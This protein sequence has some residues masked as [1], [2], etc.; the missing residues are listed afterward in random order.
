MAD[1]L[2]QKL[3]EI[4]DSLHSTSPHRYEYAAELASDL[5]TLCTEQ[6]TET[7]LGRCNGCPSCLWAW[8]VCVCVCG[9]LVLVKLRMLCIELCKVVCDRDVCILALYA[10]KDCSCWASVCVLV[11]AF[12]SAVLFQKD[13]SVIRLLH[14]LAAV[15]EVWQKWLMYCK[16]TP[17]STGAHLDASVPTSSAFV[18][19]QLHFID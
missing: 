16:Y 12:C 3:H 19:I 4:W 1:S 15:E 9:L 17:V 5:H 14:E 8:L 10:R 7:D 6:V 18:L 11:S 13:K 2:R